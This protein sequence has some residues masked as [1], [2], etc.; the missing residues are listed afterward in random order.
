MALGG[1]SFSPQGLLLQQ[2]EGESPCVSA[3]GKGDNCCLFTYVAVA[4]GV[5]VAISVQQL[6]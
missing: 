1:K 6:W 3:S 2:P 4:A 5:G